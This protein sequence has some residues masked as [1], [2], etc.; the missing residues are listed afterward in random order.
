LILSLR[1]SFQA[2]GVDPGTTHPSMRSEIWEGLDWLW[3]QRLL[4]TLALMLGVWNL[5][6]TATLAIFVLYALEIL[7]L[8]SATYGVLL[9]TFAAGSLIGSFT[10]RRMG[11]R[12][13]TGATLLICV[14]LGAVSAGVLGLTSSAIVAGA[15]MALEGAVGTMWNILTISLRQAII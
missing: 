15:M 6:G 9:T 14:S 1:G 11:A 3:H 10:A 12:L 13:G 4:R 7:G 8:H 5:F 2:R